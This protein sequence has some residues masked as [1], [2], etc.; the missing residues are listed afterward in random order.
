MYF[1]GGGVCLDITM[2]NTRNVKVA[3]DELIAELNK[4]RRALKRKYGLV[5]PRNKKR[6]RELDS[7]NFDFLSRVVQK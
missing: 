7:E 3:Q 6:R 1:N 4:H 5:I 2:S